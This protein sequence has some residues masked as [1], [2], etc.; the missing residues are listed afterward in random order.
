[1][2][3]NFHILYRDL[4]YNQIIEVP[5][6][7]SESLLYYHLDRNNLTYADYDAFA[8]VPN[9]RTLKLSYNHMEL[10]NDSL[11]PLGHLREL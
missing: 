4:G 1:M 8:G 7:Q 11:R 3:S 10:H 2:S 5:K 6:L 9:V